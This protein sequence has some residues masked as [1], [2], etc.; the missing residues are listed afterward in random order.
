MKPLVVLISTALS[1]TLAFSAQAEP[2]AKLEKQLTEA[3]RYNPSTGE[4]IG[5]SGKAIQAYMK[6]G[7]VNK[8]PNVRVDY[9]DYYLLN[10]PA[11]FMGHHLFM[12]EEEYLIKYIGCCV[13]EGAGVTLRIRA[14]D[15]N[16]RTF[17]KQNGCA[18]E[19]GV[20]IT[21]HLDDLGLKASAPAGKYITLSCRMR[22]AVRR[23]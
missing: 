10:K 18:V 21:E 1:C 4:R 5:N 2:M 14:S 9:T 12:I 7:L 19:D 6:A 8:K 11:S 15:K 16:L 20:N 3:L 22:D 13:S 23:D 17:A